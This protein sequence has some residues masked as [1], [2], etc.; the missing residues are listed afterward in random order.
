[1]FNNMKI[2]QDELN[3]IISEIRRVLKDGRII[4]KGVLI[5]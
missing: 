3:F 1:M 5:P 4:G 2:S